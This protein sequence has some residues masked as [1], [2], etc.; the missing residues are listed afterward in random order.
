MNKD[1]I[2]NSDDSLE[3]IQKKLNR[4]NKETEILKEVSIKISSSLDL[5]ITLNTLLE[6]LDNYFSYRHSMIL[7]TSEGQ[8]FLTV[9]ASYGYPDQGIG[10]K[11]E[12]GKG[13]IGM[14]AKKKQIVRLGNIT[15]NLRYLSAGKEIQ[16]HPENEIIIKLP[17]LSNPIS[18]VAIPL[19]INE[20]LVGVLSV[21][22]TEVNIFKDED[23]NL[24][25]LLAGQAAIA[26]QNAQ[27]FEAERNRY[28]EVQEIN[29]RLS[30]LTKEQQ[31]TLNLFVKFVPEPVVQKAL[32]D[33]SDS[34]FTG[35]QINIAILFCDIR[36][37][38]PISEQISPDEVVTLLNSYYSNMNRIIKKYD[39]V[40]N[41][42]V[43]DEIC[44]TFG[45]PV[46]IINCEE[47]AVLCAIS[48]IEQLEIL[49]QELNKSLGI[50]IKVGIGV[51]FGPVV[52]GNLGSEEKIEYSVTGDTVNT[53]KRIESLTKKIP[54]SILIGE[55]IYNKTKHLIETKAWDPIK[56][57]GKNE[58]VSVYQV[59]GHIES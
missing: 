44:V 32:S 6:L 5:N 38:T 48:M 15:A 25:S 58:K 14:V 22:S 46:S 16:N 45:A 9:F 24:I 59:L 26:I 55:S 47:K 54:N 4:K 10:A 31:K 43:G 56:V 2:S 12:V 3:R 8:R 21:E 50:E 17:G 33:K 20:E 27:L 49:N 29:N 52:A 23:E 19:L 30:D 37:F 53:A 28:K 57:K 42:F 36:G 34:I 35:E 7:L 1:V 41:Q 13:I 51:N 11:V 40:V 39:G 18:H